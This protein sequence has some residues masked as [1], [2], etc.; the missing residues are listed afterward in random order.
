MRPK[1]LV[2]LS[3]ALDKESGVHQSAKNLSIEKLNP[4]LGE[5]RKRLAGLK[6]T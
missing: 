2:F 3:P 4:E 6:G 5:P 1:V